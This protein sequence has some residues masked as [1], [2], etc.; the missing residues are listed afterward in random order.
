MRNRWALSV[1]VATLALLL[2]LAPWRAVGMAAQMGQMTPLDQ[3]SGDDFDKAFL[4]QMTMH[5]SMA[6]MMARPAAAQSAH[7]E[8]RDLA[9][10]IIADQTREIAQMRSWAKDW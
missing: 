10:S 5:H 2:T 7:Q 4:V 8:T 3:L 1:A 9:Q 6:V